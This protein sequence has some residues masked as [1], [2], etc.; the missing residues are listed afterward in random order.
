MP[1]VPSLYSW[2]GACP[3]KPAWH[4]FALGAFTTMQLTIS[5]ATEVGSTLQTFPLGRQRNLGLLYLCLNP[6]L[7]E[8]A[9]SQEGQ[10]C[11]NYLFSLAWWPSFPLVIGGPENCHVKEW[12]TGKVRRGEGDRQTPCCFLFQNTV[13]TSSNRMTGWLAVSSNYEYNLGIGLVDLQT[14]IRVKESLSL[15]LLVTRR[16]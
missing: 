7:Q 5:M 13:D 15:L 4:L 10:V 6:G 14:S 12:R 11:P 1:M 2:R 3:Y 9:I 16:Q 8:A